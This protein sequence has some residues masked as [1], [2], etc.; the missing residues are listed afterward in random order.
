[1]SAQTAPK[2]VS[3]SADWPNDRVVRGATLGIRKVFR[4]E[5][6]RLVA[7]LQ[8]SKPW[9]FVS[10]TPTEPAV[11]VCE[12]CAFVGQAFPPPPKATTGSGTGTVE[13]CAVG[14]REYALYCLTDSLYPFFRKHKRCRP[15]AP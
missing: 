1:M 3:R 12:R 10:V 6:G 15:G 5:A 7:G 14:S 13:V 8:S 9:I 4:S 2:T 11:L